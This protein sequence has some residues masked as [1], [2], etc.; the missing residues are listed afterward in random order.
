MWHRAVAYPQF[1]FSM[2][3]D[4]EEAGLGI[5]ISSGKSMLFADDFV[6][7]SESRESLQKLIYRY[8]TRWRLKANVGKSAVMVF[9]I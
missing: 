9:S 4:V 2:Y 3:K 8:G 7:V 1:I 6:G 5:E